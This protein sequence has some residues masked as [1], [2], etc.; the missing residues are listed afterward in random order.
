MIPGEVRA[1]RGDD[2]AWEVIVGRRFLIA[3]TPA[4]AQAASTATGAL[5][6]AAFD[7]TLEL[8]ALIGAIPLGEH[9]VASFALAWWPATAGPLTVVVRGAGE[10]ALA[11]AAGPRRL[12]ARGIVP[13]YLAE[14]R[15]VLA[16]RLGGAGRHDARVDASSAPVGAAFRAFG[17][18][19][20]APGDADAEFM[21]GADGL[22][23]ANS[24]GAEASASP[25]EPGVA[26]GPLDAAEV[27]EPPEPIEPPRPAPR[28]RVTGG[29]PRDVADAVFIGR[30][31]V[32]PRVARGR[33]E[34]VRIEGADPGVSGTHLELR[35]EGE[36]LVATD[37][38]STNG[39]VLRAASGTRRLRAGES[40]VVAPGSVLLLGGD[41][42]VEILPPFEDRA[43]P[44]R[45]VI[46]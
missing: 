22:A 20:R 24:A 12:D 25:R 16:V 37:L 15:D 6:A 42:I 29:E 43:N 17:V 44:G 28:F 45:Q 8:E 4:P 3:F 14:F 31:P 34:L 33:V 30:R 7:E 39:T 2:P 38:R 5:A 41:T 23:P 46:V 1:V 27:P 40:V 11:T 9:G 35:R 36:Q 13:W 21:L 32:L 26:T 10:A 19:W 18:E